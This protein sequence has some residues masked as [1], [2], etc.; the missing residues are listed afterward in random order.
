MIFPWQNLCKMP[1]KLL[2]IGYSIWVTVFIQ[3]QTVEVIS[4]TY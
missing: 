3:M 4:P 1:K 2:Q